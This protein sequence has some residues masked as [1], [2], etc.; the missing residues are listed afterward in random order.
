MTGWQRAGDLKAPSGLIR[1]MK[2]SNEYMKLQV[3]K[4]LA[5]VFKAPHCIHKV[6]ENNLMKSKTK[7]FYWHAFKI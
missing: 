3:G 7:E 5:T 4:R 2:F 6:K 1:L